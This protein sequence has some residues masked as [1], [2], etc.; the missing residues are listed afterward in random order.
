MTY[1]EVLEFLYQRLPVFHRE[2]KKAFKPG[3][4]HIQFLCN[5]FGNPQSR[6]KCLHIAGTNGKGSSSHLMASILQEHGFKVGLY[7]SPHLKNFTER[8]KINGQEI[9]ENWITN[10]VNSNKELITSYSASFFE[11]TV[12]MAFLY[13]AENNVDYAII[14]TGLGGRLDSTNIVQPIACLITNISFDHQDILGN[15]LEEIANEKAGIIKT[16]IPVTISEFNESTA[17]I[18]VE[19]AKTLQ[20]P[21]QFSKNQVSIKLGE[22]LD[23]KFQVFEVH[24]NHWK[25]LK[26]KSPLLGH[27]QLQNIA[28]IIAWTIQLDQMKILSF[29]PSIICLGIENVVKNTGL[30]GRFQ[31]LQQENPLIIADTAHN[32]DGIKNVLQ[33]IQKINLKKLSFIIGMVKDKDIKKVLSLLPNDANYIFTEISNPRRLEKESLK[34]IGEETGKNGILMKDVNEAIHFAKLNLADHLVLIIGS[35]YLV[36]EINDL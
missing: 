13:F 29:D 27:Y 33:Q 4:D 20:A 12:I 32:E 19:K 31:I 5:Q 16:C 34:I 14:E 23:H 36:A 24:T 26:V 25:N 22:T 15:S 6:L 1:A 2:G 35:T 7:T 18:F 10:F 30:K 8:F 9:N 28:G 3:L 17:S 21:I 11:W